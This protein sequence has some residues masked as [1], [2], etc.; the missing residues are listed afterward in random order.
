MEILI[1]CP[2]PRGSR[3]GNRVTAERWARLLRLL[4]HR[5]RIGAVVPRRKTDVVVALHAVKSAGAVR[6]V[7][8]WHPD[9]RIVVV[10]TGTDIPTVRRGG[11]AAAAALARADRVVVLQ[12]MALRALPATL[13][14]KAR[15]IYQSIP[16]LAVAVRRRDN[17]FRVAVVAHL[18][19]VKDPLRTAYAVRALPDTSRIEVVHAGSALT[20]AWRRSAEREHTRNWRWHW[21]GEIAPRRA[22]RLIAGSDLLVISSRSEGGAHVIGEACVAG[23]PVLATRIDGNVGLL[24]ADYPGYFAVGDTRALTRLLRRA[25]Q[26]PRFLA[27][28]R[29]KSQ[30]RRALFRESRELAALHAL[31]QGIGTAKRA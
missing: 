21:L 7:A 28:L 16:P 22:Q 26:D 13:R 10:L 1:V 17:R 15:V 14:R 6:Q 18:R 24:G 20:V 31:V 30:A 8:R 4:G 3:R 29:R 9:A 2:V 12:P 23:V 25:E 27:S 5:V 19:H 11:G